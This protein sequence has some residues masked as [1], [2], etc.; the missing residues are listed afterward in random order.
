MKWEYKIIK[1]RFTS[2]NYYWVDEDTGEEILIDEDRIK[3]LNFM[4]NDGWDLA[5]A[6]DAGTYIFKRP[7]EA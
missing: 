5:V 4:G 7:V 3:V 2:G 1:A 6:K